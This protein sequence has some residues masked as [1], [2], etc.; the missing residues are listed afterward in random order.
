LHSQHIVSSKQV[1][2][3]EETNYA[4]SVHWLFRDASTW[5]GGV[6][7][8]F[9]ILAATLSLDAGRNGGNV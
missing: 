2:D 4:E 3:T 5:R 9:T 6:P 1:G 8:E 7:D